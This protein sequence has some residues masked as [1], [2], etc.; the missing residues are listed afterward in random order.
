MS[1][2]PLRR[3]R[4]HDPRLRAWR[5]LLE[6]HKELTS[7]FDAEFQERC[8]IDLSTYDALLHVYEAGPEGIRMTDLSGR[9]MITKSGLTTR[10]DRLEKEGLLRR[11]PDPADRRAIRVAIT[12][13]G[14]ALFQ[15]AAK[16]HMASIENNFSKHITDHEAQTVIDIVDR[17]L[18]AE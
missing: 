3:G 6:L 16:I 13:D 14:Y 12:D 8:D 15:S 9:L 11:V 2:P 7:L 10:I 4:R 17:I 18:R 5:A 1:Q